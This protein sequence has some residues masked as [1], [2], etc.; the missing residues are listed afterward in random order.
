MRQDATAP[1]T[2]AMPNETPS[3]STMW[4]VGSTISASRLIAMLATM[5][6]TPMNMGVRLSCSA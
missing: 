1:T 5:T 3:P 6:A 2:L 4:P